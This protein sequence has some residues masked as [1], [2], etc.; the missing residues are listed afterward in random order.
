MYYWGKPQFFGVKAAAANIGTGVGDYTVEQFREDY[1]QFFNFGCCFLG[2]LPMLEQI[3]QMANVIIQPD[4]WLDSWRYAVG[5]YVAHYTTLS[6]RGYSESNE[7]PQQ[8]AASG[9]LVGMVKSATL[10]DAS[11]T[12]DTSAITAGTEDWGDLNSTTYGQILA[13]R[14]KLIG[15]SGTYII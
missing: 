13:N 8:A 2:S 15:M 7:T 11:V 6:L 12:Y 9:A 4:K 14:A 1:P 5:L 10:G 3:I